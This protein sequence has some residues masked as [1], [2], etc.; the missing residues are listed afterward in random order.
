MPKTSSV[1]CSSREDWPNIVIVLPCREYTNAI[2]RVREAQVPVTYDIRFTAEGK[3]RL[4]RKAECE[5]MTANGLAFLP[6]YFSGSDA[7]YPR[8]MK[9]F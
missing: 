4:C 5:A 3:D 2:Y 7:E 8:S 1:V 6:L 9:R